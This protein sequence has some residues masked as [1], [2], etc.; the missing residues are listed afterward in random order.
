MRW[1]FSR[2]DISE[3][4]RHAIGEALDIETPCAPLGHASPETV[5]SDFSSSSLVKAA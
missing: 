1:T 5:S 2:R 3:Y 4:C